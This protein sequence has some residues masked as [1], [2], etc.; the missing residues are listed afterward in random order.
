MKI[1]ILIPVAEKGGCE[2]IINMLVP[3]LQRR[4]GYNIR[5]V[6]LIYED[7]TWI[8]KDIAYYPLLQGRAGHNLE[9]LVI[10]YKN[11]FC[12]D[13][14]PDVILATAWPFMCYVAKKA[15]AMISQENTFIFSWLHS[16]V[17]R[18][19]SAG[20]G[21]FPHLALADAHLAIS[22]DIANEITSVL[23][24]ATVIP[25]HNPVDF[26]AC[27]IPDDTSLQ[28]S[29]SIKNLYF[30]G[31]ISAEKRLDLMIRALQGT[32]NNL[33]LFII[34]DGEPALK[35]QLYALAEE[36]G[37]T[38]SIE[39]LGWK[40]APWKHV[41]SPSAFL[42]A[43]DYEGFPLTSIEALCNGIPVIS[44]PVS[45]ITDIIVP[46]VNGYLFPFNDWQSLHQILLLLG[47]NQLPTIDPIACQQSV[48]PHRMEDALLDFADK[49]EAC[50]HK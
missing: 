13:G 33:K 32:E 42:M 44:T 40:N 49:I 19:E 30:I 21:S 35:E 27:K 8:H 16:P 25:V 47:N 23:P 24:D 14:A 2:N 29:L 3:F 5:V 22:H 26:T 6:Q 50:L 7:T 43:S 39:W 31:R 28:N 46:G 4:C 15:L 34:G 20:F 1:D 38:G 17:K 11:F 36:C 10:T 41:Y 48:L 9:E 18:Y 37:V 45:G 12:K